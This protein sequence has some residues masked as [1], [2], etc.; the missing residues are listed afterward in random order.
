MSSLRG[1][2]ILIVAAM[3]AVGVLFFFLPAMMKAET[4]RKRRTDPKYRPAVS[5]GVLDEIFHPSAYSAV[6]E[7]ETQQALP[8]PAP[9]PGD[10][11]RRAKRKEA[12]RGAASPDA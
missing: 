9:A 4:R 3:I 5:I 1:M 7:L 11:N 2:E 10:P 6:E 12:H 8:A